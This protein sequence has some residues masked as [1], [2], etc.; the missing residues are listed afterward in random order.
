MQQYPPQINEQEPLPGTDVDTQTPELS[1]SAIV[2]GGYPANPVFS[3]AFKILNGPNPATA[4]VV[5]SSGWVA[6]S[7]NS[8]TRRP[9]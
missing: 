8:W 7:G 2:P 1:A 3:Y 9:A 4:T 6:N 5:A